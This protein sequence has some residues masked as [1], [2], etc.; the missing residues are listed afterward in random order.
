[1]RQLISFAMRKA[2]AFSLAVAAFTAVSSAQQPSLI[3]AHV[4][5]AADRISA[6]QIAKDLEFLAS[7]KLAGRNTPSPGFDAAAEYIADRL[8]RAGLKPAGDTGTFFQHYTMRETTADTAKS[9]I[10]IAGSRFAF[11]DGFVL[12]SCAGPVSGTFRMVYAGHGWVY[13][14]GDPYSGL[15]VRGKIIVV[16][17]PRALPKG[18]EIR[19]LGRLTPGASSAISEAARR[20]A[21]GVIRACGARGSSSARLRCRSTASSRTS[22]ST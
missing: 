7:D 10:E 20:G 13:S 12:R 15:D 2:L 6:A 19:Q 16:H 18:V 11:G 5:A 17:G 1:M 3:P 8:T 4:R 14:G 21:A 9:F 22:T